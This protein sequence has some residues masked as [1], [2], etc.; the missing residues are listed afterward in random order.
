MQRRIEIEIH[1]HGR[2]EIDTK[3]TPFVTSVRWER[4]ISAPW[5]SLSVSWKAPL[6]DSFSRV[7]PGDWVV[8]RILSAATQLG[9][10]LAR[11]TTVDGGAA[12][13][14]A[15]VVTD[16]S[17][18][19][20]V[21]W[22]AFLAKTAVFTPRGWAESTGSLFS[23]F[24][25]FNTIIPADVTQYDGRVGQSLANVFA[26]M[27]VVKLPNSLTGGTDL[28]LGDVIPVV[29]NKDTQ[30]QFAP[31]RVIESVDIGSGPPG[32][33]A[34]KYQAVQATVGDFIQGA[35]VPEPL[36]MELFPSFE[37]SVEQPAPQQSFAGSAL[38][39]LL[40]GWETLIYRIKPFRTRALREAAV[41][42]V[43]YKHLEIEAV[44]RGAMVR[45]VFSPATL[46][47]SAAEAGRAATQQDTNSG[48]NLLTSAYFNEITWNYLDSISIPR[49]MMRR[50]S[51]QLDDSKRL[52]CGTIRLSLSGSDEI[53]AWEA[54]GL[55]IRY[56]EEILRHGLRINMPHWPFTF[57]PKL[58]NPDAGAQ[59]SRADKISDDA[60]VDYVTY[61]R[62]IVAQFMQFYKNNHLYGSGTVDINFG[63]AVRISEGKDALSVDQ[64]L[65]L[66]PGEIIE[67]DLPEKYYAYAETIK[68]VFSIAEGGVE[69]ASTSITFT[70]GHFKFPEDFLAQTVEVPISATQSAEADRDSANRPPADPSA[71]GV[72]GQT[73]AEPGFFACRDGRPA[74]RF[75]VEYIYKNQTVMGGRRP[76][77]EARADWIRGWAVTRGVRLE[78]FDRS[79]EPSGLPSSN[80]DGTRFE[81]VKFDENGIMDPRYV[82]DRFFVAM[83]CAYIVEAYWRLRYPEA[84]IKFVGNGPLIREASGRGLENDPSQNHISGSAFDFA[85]YLD[86]TTIVPV[87]QT[88]A[89]LHRLALAGRI[90]PGAMGL[91]LNG[92]P[93]TGIQGTAWAQSGLA[94]QAGF[95]PGSAGGVHYDFRGAYRRKTNPRR[96][97]DYELYNPT[98]SPLIPGTKYVWVNSRGS[99]N[100]DL[101]YA[102]ATAYLATRVPTVLVYYNTKGAL[103][104]TLWSAESDIIPN[105]E[106][107]LGNEESCFIQGKPL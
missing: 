107:L 97:E 105:V 15:T 50:F 78:Y 54:A 74:E 55:P 37:P 36:L 6:G 1:R 58:L 57:P 30:R 88:W 2:A 47:V 46:A 84:R 99:G 76:L 12:L 34:P 23:M 29:H 9:A 80:P 51:A 102:E 21:G 31:T 35:Y 93:A 11:V 14:N 20:A 38:R 104:P 89:S 94:V 87:L 90:P 101:M 70:R 18:F 72:P 83:A 62:T 4:S 77:I 25:W 92:S 96:V 49:S 33:F 43:D 40:G 59:E 28:T 79:T 16:P 42:W 17:R 103:D 39:G 7:L 41:A 64:I 52:N 5:Q 22:W 95:P 8:F 81:L 106:Q 65:K 24:D 19:E 71:A 73:V 48:T 63:Q 13:S 10:M 91:Y 66:K 26:A 68:H 45:S 69:S 44:Y 100:S 56:N 32:Y 61:L 98:A 67:L 27:S 53:T 85:I 82:G 60:S 3:I 86:S 75:P